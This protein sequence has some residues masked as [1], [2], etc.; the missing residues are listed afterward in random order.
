M[1]W[2]LAL[3]FGVR[4]QSGAATA[5]LKEQ[6]QSS[7]CFQSGVALRLPPQSK[8]FT[9]QCHFENAS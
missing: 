8:I 4:W 3:V 5:L 1:A 7:V 6:F 2:S 9:G